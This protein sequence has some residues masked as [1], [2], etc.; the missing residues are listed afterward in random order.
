MDKETDLQD[1]VPMV[2]AK[3]QVVKASQALVSFAINQD[4]SAKHASI[5]VAVIDVGE[6]GTFS[7]QLPSTSPSSF[8]LPDA[9]GSQPTL[10][11]L[12]DNHQILTMVDILLDDKPFSCLCNTGAEINLVP[13][14]FAKKHAMKIQRQPGRW[15][16]CTIQRHDDSHH[17]NWATSNPGY[18]LYC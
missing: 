6:K 18:F 5:E 3:V 14:N 7:M 16:W 17:S 9:G 13:A 10:N 2:L 4:I 8:K 11:A 1:P 12:P 15:N